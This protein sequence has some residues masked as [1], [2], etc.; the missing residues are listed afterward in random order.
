VRASAT[1]GEKFGRRFQNLCLQLGQ[2]LT[3]EVGGRLNAGRCA[4]I[5]A[6]GALLL[7]TAEGWQKFYSGVLR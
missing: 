3:I 1:E 6:D 4:G 2:E 7:E 5:A